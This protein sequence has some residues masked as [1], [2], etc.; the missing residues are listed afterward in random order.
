MGF[1]LSVC[2]DLGFF[3]VLHFLYFIFFKKNVLE[4]LLQDKFSFKAGVV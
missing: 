1:G 4:V 2:L 3:L